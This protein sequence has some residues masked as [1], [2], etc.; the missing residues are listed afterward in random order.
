MAQK[1][2]CDFCEVDCTNFYVWL[3]SAIPPMMAAD[4]K[5][6]IV[7]PSYFCIGCYKTV[8]RICQKHSIPIQTDGGKC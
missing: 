2:Y 4:E 1:I 5:I 3:S 7:P 6:G 8:K